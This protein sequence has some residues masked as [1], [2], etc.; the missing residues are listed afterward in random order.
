[1]NKKN[2]LICI[3][4][5]VLLA[6]GYLIFVA[7]NSN[8]LDSKLVS[9]CIKAGA[10]YQSPAVLGEKK[11]ECCDGLA[12]IEESNVMQAFSD[13]PLEV[14]GALICSACGNGSCEIAWENKCNCPEDCE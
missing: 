6:I 8:K 1:M 7:V 2:I 13:C 5:V 4:V 3:L 11:G 12:S 9:T 14:G 10:V